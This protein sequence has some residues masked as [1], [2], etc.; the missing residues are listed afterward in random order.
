MRD[1]LSGRLAN[2]V[3]CGAV[4]TLAHCVLHESSSCHWAL[5]VLV[6]RA[7]AVAG[8]ALL[9]GLLNLDTIV[10]NVG[11][12]EGHKQ[13]LIH[14]EVL[15]NEVDQQAKDGLASLAPDVQGNG[16]FQVAMHVVR[17]L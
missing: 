2:L 12:G 5:G 4:N 13:Q 17:V 6:V 1:M 7:D 3:R 11:E 14:L 15:V 8:Q 9:D 16:G 10:S